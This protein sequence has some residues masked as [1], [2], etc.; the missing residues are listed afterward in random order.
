MNPWHILMTALRM[1]YEELFHLLLIG[2]L[3]TAAVLIPPAL[4]LWLMLQLPAPPLV[5]LLGLP[6]ALSL[7]GMATLG[8]VW[9]AAHAALE[10]RGVTWPLFW[11]GVQLHGGRAIKS[12]ALLGGGYLVIASNLLFYGSPLSPLAP[13]LTLWVNLVWSGVAL[14]WTGIGFYLLSFQFEMEA[15]RLFLSLRNSFFMTL[16]HP[17]N[18]LVWLVCTG[19][20]SLLII[21]LPPI[22]FLLPPWIAILSQTGLRAQLAPVREKIK[23]TPDN[24]SHA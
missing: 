16:L 8:G 22:L 5:L 21:I 13:E 12:V 18:T 11:E 20:F 17:L 2:A 7:P 10:E 24:T 23:T 4:A 19:L 6:L 9:W 15:P 1:F 3:V 14:V